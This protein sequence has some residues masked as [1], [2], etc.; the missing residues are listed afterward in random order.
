MKEE[1]VTTE[2]DTYSDIE[3]IIEP[4]YYYV[5]GDRYRITSRRKF[6]SC[7]IYGNRVCEMCDTHV[8]DGN[9]ISYSIWTVCSLDCL[10]KLVER[11]NN[12]RNGSN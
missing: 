7:H 3:K 10:N 2:N 9:D 8:K 6:S 1:W 12:K 4:E 5:D 11:E